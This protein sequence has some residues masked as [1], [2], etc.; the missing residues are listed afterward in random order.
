MINDLPKIVVLTPVKNEAWIL[1]R[2]LSVTSQFA[3]L[4]IIA[5]QNSTDGSWEIYKHYPKVHV[6][7]NKDQTYDEASRQLLLIET[8]R[9][10]VPGRRILLAF[11]S[12]E[13]MAADAMQSAEWQTLLNAKPGTVL[14][15]EKPDLCYSPDKCLRWR[16]SPWPLGYVD[17]GIEHKPSKVHSIRIPSPPYATLLVFNKIKVL[18]YAFT[19][20]SSQNAKMRMYSVVENNLNT[21]NFIKRRYRYSKNKQWHLAGPM[22]NSNPDWFSS[23]EKKGIDMTSISEEKYYWQDYSVLENFKKF[24]CQKYWYDD[25]WDVNWNHVKSSNSQYASLNIIQPPVYLK[26]FVRVTDACFKF[27]KEKLKF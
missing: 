20:I 25:I 13:I 26:L 14:L 4:I 3:D 22:E 10:L 5:D 16:R 24:G 1:D 6:I 19:R 15:F 27:Y 11:D 21:L 9:K 8:A 7:E 2:F 12:D 17:D 18:H 23:W